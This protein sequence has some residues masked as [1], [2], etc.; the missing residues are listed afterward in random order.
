MISEAEALA[1][2]L[3][4]TEPLPS[5]SRPLAEALGRFT[6]RDLHARWP[7]PLFDNSSMDGYALLARDSGAG[8]RL[9]VTGE[10]PAGVDRELLVRAGEAVRIFTG[11]PIPA[12]ADAVIMQEDVTAEDAKIALHGAAEPGENIRRRGSDLAEGQKL[13]AAGERIGPATI[14]LL[15]AQGFADVQTGGDARVAIISTGDELVA[16]GGELQPGQLYESN[17]LLLAALVREAGGEVAMIEHCADDEAQLRAAF[18]RALEFPAFIVSGGVSVGA[19]DFVKPVLRALGVEIELWRVAIKPGKPFLF[20]AHGGCH[21][22]GLP[23]NPV[24]AFVTFLQFVRP[25]LRRMIGAGE[26]ALRLPQFPARL[27]TDLRNDGD[28]P[29]Y[30][31]G[32][33][34]DGI[35]DVA[36]RQESHALFG[37]SRAN[38]L[39][40]LSPNERRRAG[41]MV[42]VQ[43][44]SAAF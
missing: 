16:S 20:S 1:R 38:A 2:L 32:S 18:A 10:Q 39:L 9:H 34:A 13:L 22:F 36:G 37:L 14:A 29:H 44:W 26:H 4:K 28:R 35:F 19:R 33:L 15:A 40:R 21:I 41:D 43:L 27:A 12:G 3:A 25:A 30:L 8:V 24:S 7:L 31:R 11:A 6:A 5:R 42:Q 17:S 23:G